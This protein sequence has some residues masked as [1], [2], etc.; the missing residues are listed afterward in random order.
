MSASEKPHNVAFA[1][2]TYEESNRV[3]EILRKE[4]VGGFIL[5]AATVL[6]VVLANSPASGFYFG[7]RDAEVGAHVP[8]FYHL[9]MS[10]GTWAADGLLVVFFFLTPAWSSKKSSWW[11]ICVIPVKLL[12]LSPQLLV[13]WRCQR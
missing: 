13:V 3:A 5:L 7:L 8:G 2:G 10:V 12:C 6:A 4:T 1:R 9:M 11:A